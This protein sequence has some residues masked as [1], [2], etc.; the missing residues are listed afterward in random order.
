MPSNNMRYWIVSIAYIYAFASIQAKNNE[1]I[2]FV[3]N[4]TGVGKLYLE[5]YA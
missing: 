5:I 4:D 1:D 2:T 3:F